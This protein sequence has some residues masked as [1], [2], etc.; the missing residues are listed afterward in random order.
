MLNVKT[1]IAV[2]GA[3]MM[4]ASAAL[5]QPSYRATPETAP[6]NARVIIRDMGWTCHAGICSAV[7]TGASTDAT[8]CGAVARSLGRLARFAT[9]SA[10]FDAVALGKCNKRAQ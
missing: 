6:A 5:A 3:G 9:D 2:T 10:A 1:A 8:V 7:R 4:I